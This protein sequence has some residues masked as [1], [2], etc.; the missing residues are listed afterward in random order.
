MLATA[1]WV[2][3]LL[4]LGVYGDDFMPY[5]EQA[6]TTTGTMSATELLRGTGNWVAYLHFGEAWL[7]AGWTVVTATVTILGSAFAAALGLAGLARRDLPERRWLLLTVLAVVL[8]ALAGYA[9]SFGAPFHDTVRDWL[10]GPLRPF[11]SIYKFQPGLALALAFGLMHLVATASESRGARPF[12]LRR[13][14]PALAA[15]LILPGLAWPY[16]NGTILQPGA[17]KKLPGQWTQA[18]DWLAKNSPT[19]AP[20]SSPPPPTASTPGALPS[21]SPSTC[22]PTPAGPSATSCPS[23]RRARGVRWTRWIRHS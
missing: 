8:I 1:W 23:G 19:A 14:A 3:P 13:H 18:A 16:A 17:F 2:I 21:T 22:S 10:N 4:L 9:G 7:P 6:D 11:R 20:S 12:P 5:V 15:L